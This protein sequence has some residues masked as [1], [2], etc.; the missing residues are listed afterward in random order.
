MIAVV[1]LATLAVWVI[2]DVALCVA[3]HRARRA[4]PKA[5]ATAPSQHSTDAGWLLDE[6]LEVTLT[7]TEVELRLRDIEAAEGWVR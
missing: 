4:T 6:P 2:V 5:A 1:V 3:N 7:D